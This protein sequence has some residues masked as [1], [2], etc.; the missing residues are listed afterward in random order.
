[1]SEIADFQQLNKQRV[2][3]HVAIIMD[4]NG[5]WAKD[6]GQPRIFGHKAGVESVRTSVSYACQNGIK[7]LTL[8][9]FSSENWRRPKDEVSGLM[10]LFA[11][12]L[13]NE[14][15][16][17]HKNQVK[18]KVIGDRDVFSDS[19]RKRID[20]AEKLT[21]NNSG[22][23][24]NIAVNYGGRWDIVN[25]VKKILNDAATDILNIKDFNESMI[26]EHLEVS[27]DVDLLIRTGGEKRISNFLLWQLAYSEI[28]VSDVLWPDFNEDVFQKAVNYFASRER[29]FGCTGEQIRGEKQ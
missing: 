17:L 3:S 21:E 14:V 25:A 8:F 18:L 24:L 29:R 7:V 27:Q 26:S 15:K 2:P 4:G 1:M 9:A 12:A 20:E 11:W 22:L 19:F 28:Y 13:S 6:R 5:R 10:D 23:L 16:K